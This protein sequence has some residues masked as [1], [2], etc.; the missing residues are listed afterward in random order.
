MLTLEQLASTYSDKAPRPPI[1]LNSER[2][3]AMARRPSW[4][5]A[6]DVDADDLDEIVDDDAPLDCPRPTRRRSP[7]WADFVDGEVTRFEAHYNGERKTYPEWAALWRQ[8]WWP[9]LD[10][11]R[12]F[13]E[14][15]PPSPPH[16]FFR[17]GAPE[18][19]LALEI[20]TRHEVGLW[21]RFDVAQLTPEDPRLAYLATGD[22]K[23]VGRQILRL[24]GQQF[25]DGIVCLSSA[26]MVHGLAVRVDAHVWMWGEE[27]P[28]N[29][30]G[31]RLLD[32]DPLTFARGHTAHPLDDG[33][34]VRV[35]TPARSI[36][37]CFSWNHIVGLPV[38][39]AALRKGLRRK[40]VTP[41]ELWKIAERR[42]VAGLL[43]KE[44][45]A[46]FRSTAR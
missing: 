25:P 22:R 3:W 46:A 6:D 18:F 45:L 23:A 9:R 36:V 10:V 5:P 1:V 20:G 39:R 28:V 16:P 19:D 13:A 8:T 43:V 26:L 34:S 37:D 15:A 33:R 44:A 11:R 4:L 32:T 31:V 30:R 24:A 42:K 21:R 40:I 17:R 41:D 7:R 38:A 12:I 35:T 27:L 2:Q 14:L 29:A